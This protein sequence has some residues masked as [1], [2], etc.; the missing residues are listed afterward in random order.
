[1]NL[2]RN[3]RYLCNDLCYFLVSRS[4]DCCHRALNCL[5]RLR[6][7]RSGASKFD[8][9][10]RANFLRTRDEE[11]GEAEVYK[12]MEGALFFFH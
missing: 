3:L 2:T 9:D 10:L 1:M 6:Q 8:R 7:R 11:A 5:E 12:A 4:T